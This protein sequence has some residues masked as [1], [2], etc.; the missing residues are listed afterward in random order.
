MKGY[1]NSARAAA[2]EGDGGD[3]TGLALP[4]RLDELEIAVITSRDDSGER[5]IREL[6][7][8]RARVQHIWPVPEQIPEIYDVVYCDFVSDVAQRLRW[9]PGDPP[10]T[11][12]LIVSPAQ[13][14][15]LQ[16]LHNCAPD[17]VIHLPCPPH[18]VLSSL[19]LARSHFLYTQRLRKK[20]DK[21]D[22]NL[23]TMRSVERAKVILMQTRNISEE[24]A[25]HFLRRQA[26]EK[27]VTIG[28]LACTIVD[29]QELLC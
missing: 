14:I 26:M 20:I 1:Q 24:E 11:L 10:A 19:T 21:L 13:R 7:R 2:G 17:G 3:S 12:V 8:T 5:L 27:R 23:R 15:E 18:A 22:E 6:Q 4:F 28:L 16:M 25:Y 29:S 9:S